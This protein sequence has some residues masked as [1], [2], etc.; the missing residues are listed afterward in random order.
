MWTRRCSRMRC[1]IFVRLLRGF[2]FLFAFY[3]NSRN[4]S[5]FR[6]AYTACR[7]LGI[8]LVALGA[9]TVS[10]NWN[11]I[12]S[13]SAHCNFRWRPLVFGSP[14]LWRVDQRFR[15]LW[16]IWVL[17]LLVLA[18]LVVTFFSFSWIFRSRSWPLVSRYPTSPLASHDAGLLL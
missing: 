9:A 3:N 4:G 6:I 11:K 1:Q 16:R 2:N 18:G 14:L 10:R 5:F 12:F 15:D 8:S 13:C 17:L 7:K